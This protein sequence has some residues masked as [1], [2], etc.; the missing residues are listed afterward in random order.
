MYYVKPLSHTTCHIYV[1]RFRKCKG[2]GKEKHLLNAR[3]CQALH[4]CFPHCDHI[5][6]AQGQVLG[7]AR[8]WTQVSLRAREAVLVCRLCTPRCKLQSQLHYS[9]DGALNTWVTHW[10]SASRV[11]H[12]TPHSCFSSA[13]WVR[14]GT[15]RQCQM[16][17]K[18]LE[19]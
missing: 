10:V 8:T 3:T 5:H 6:S 12:P 15:E 11:V 2:K 19:S 18:L 9:C 4:L 14:W 7:R 13:E 17:R 1:L 16:H